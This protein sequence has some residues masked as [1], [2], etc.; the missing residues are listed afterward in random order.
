MT[1]GKKMVRYPD[2]SSSSARFFANASQKQGLFT[3]M[4]V[5]QLMGRQKDRSNNFIRRDKLTLRI[6]TLSDAEFQRNG[7]QPGTCPISVTWLLVK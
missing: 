7:K 6:V 2:S 5:A 4:L 1:I 3:L